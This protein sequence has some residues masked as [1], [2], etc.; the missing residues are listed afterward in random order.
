LLRFLPLFI[1]ITWQ[2]VKII[3]AFCYV[4]NKI[5]IFAS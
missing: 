2:Y 4:H 3:K 5:A 1:K